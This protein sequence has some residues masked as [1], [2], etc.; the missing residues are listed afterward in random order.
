MAVRGVSYSLNN[1]QQLLF[2]LRNANMA[3]TTDQIFTKVFSGTLYDPVYIVVNCKSGA[4]NTAC[5]GGVYTGANKTGS[6]IIAV[7][8]SYATL[9]GVNTQVHPAVQATLVSFSVTPILSLT[10]GNTGALVADWFFYGD[11]VD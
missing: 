5:A 9:T 10:T 8:Q 11:C 6:A 1:T 4:F 2:V 7:G 3:I